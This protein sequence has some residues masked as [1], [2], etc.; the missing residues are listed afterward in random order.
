[1]KIKDTFVIQDFDDEYI[2][3]ETGDDAFRG[4]VRCNATAAYIVECL[5]SETTKEEIVTAMCAKYD[6]SRETIE[7]SVDRMLETLRSV[8]AIDEV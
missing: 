7:K 1:M 3:V 5:K 8:G 4:I 2:L 6:A